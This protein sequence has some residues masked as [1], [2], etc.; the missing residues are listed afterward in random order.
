MSWSRIILCF[1]LMGI[2]I[3]VV[4]LWIIA[5]VK[6]NQTPITEVPMWAFI[7]LGGRR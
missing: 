3:A 5:M 4:I 6:Y 1:M 2:G 7:I